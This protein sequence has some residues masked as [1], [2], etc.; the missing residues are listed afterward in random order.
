MTWQRRPGWSGWWTH[1]GDSWTPDPASPLPFRT[2]RTLAD[3]P[4][5]EPPPPGGMLCPACGLRLGRV[6][7]SR[8]TDAG[9]R[10]RRECPN[11]HRA[12]TVETVA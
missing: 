5:P 9:V 3:D 11:G 6:V 4:E 12:S 10:R 7:D 8:T 1:E 2:T